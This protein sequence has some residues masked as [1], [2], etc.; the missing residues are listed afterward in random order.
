[1][2]LSNQVEKSVLG[3]AQKCEKLEK[4]RKRVVCVNYNLKWRLSRFKTTVCVKY[5]LKWRRSRFKT[6]A[7]DTL[8]LLYYDYL[9]FGLFSNG[10]PEVQASRD[11]GRWY[12]WW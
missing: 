11:C 1:M 3:P 9:D 7:Y 6:T 12:S 4:S 5:S 8:R 10:N 2:G